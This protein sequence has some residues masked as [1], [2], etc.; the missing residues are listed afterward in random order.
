MVLTTVGPAALLVVLLHAA[1]AQ[2][3]QTDGSGSGGGSVS[4]Q[5]DTVLARTHAVPSVHTPNSYAWQRADAAGTKNPLHDL[6][7]S[8]L[9][10]LGTDHIRY[11]QAQDTNG[12]NNLSAY[13]EPYP[14]DKATKATS[15]DHLRTGIDPYVVGNGWPG[16]S[17]MLRDKPSQW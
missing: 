7:Y 8:R 1:Q 11:M 14:P 5:W 15:W 17:H 6:L 12:L 2:D 16:K 9:K 10:E 3:A 4:V 13:P